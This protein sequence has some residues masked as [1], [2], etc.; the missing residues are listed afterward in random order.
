M[1]STIDLAHSLR[2]YKYKSNFSISP[3]NIINK[4]LENI[5]EKWLYLMIRINQKLSVTLFI[6]LKKC[7]NTIQ[8]LFLVL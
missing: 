7:T 5:I 1:L 6:N 8:H 2:N 3:F 4:C